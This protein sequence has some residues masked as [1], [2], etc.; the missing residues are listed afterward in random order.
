M[1]NQLFILFLFCILLIA[2]CAV[3]E[4]CRTNLNVSMEMGLYHVVRNKTLDT[5]TTSTL[6][7]DSLTVKGLRF[8]SLAKKYVYVDSI[9]YNNSKLVSSINL[10][11][12]NFEPISVF[13]I[14][15]NN[16]IITNNLITNKKDTIPLTNIKDTLTV[17][18]ENTNKY[19]SLDCGSIKVH[20]IDTAYTTK[21]FI[22][23]IHIVN[24]NV[25]NINAENIK[26][27]K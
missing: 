4:Q 14:T 20:T 25:N 11:L 1:K 6:T 9:I 18:H 21:N 12:H 3:D 19:L 15:F 8:D 2:S 17:I 16:K 5:I 13:E 7:I 27:F 10:P 24:H 23:S 22:D 26:I